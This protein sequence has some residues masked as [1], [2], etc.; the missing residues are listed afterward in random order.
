[1][2]VTCQRD[3]SLNIACMKLSL[4]CKF[5]LVSSWLLWLLGEVKGHLSSTS[6]KIWK[7]CKEGNLR[8]LAFDES[9]LVK[10]HMGSIYVNVYNF[11][12]SKSKSVVCIYSMYIHLLK[13]KELSVLCRGWRSPEFNRC[14]SLKCL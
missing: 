5:P 1:M 7:P 8:I 6:G 4:V 2:Y 14:Q 12:N 11:C 13:W 10:G 3:K 9:H